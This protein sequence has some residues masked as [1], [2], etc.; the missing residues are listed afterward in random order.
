MP[1]PIGI[2]TEKDWDE[3]NQAQ[4]SS[5]LSV[6]AFGRQHAVNQQAFLRHR[7]QWQIKCLQEAVEDFVQ[8][9]PSDQPIKDTTTAVREEKPT[10]SLNVGQVNVCFCEKTSP[11]WV[12]Q[13]IREVVV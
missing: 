7:D 5:Q 10:I 6:A 2:R 8:I 11:Q 1:K 13:L 3:L 4:R 12:A 9:S